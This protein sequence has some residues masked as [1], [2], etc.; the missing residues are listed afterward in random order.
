M[1]IY[2]LHRTDRIKGWDT[3]SS[4]CMQKEHLG[5]S[6]ILPYNIHRCKLCHQELIVWRGGT[7]KSVGFSYTSK[8]IRLKYTVINISYVNPMVTTKKIQKLHK[9]KQNQSLSIQEN[10]IQ[11]K[12]AGEKKDERITRQNKMAKVS[13]FL[14]II[15][16]NINRLNSPITRVANEFFFL[17]QLKSYHMLFTRKLHQIQGHSKLKVER[18]KKRYSIQMVTKRKH[19]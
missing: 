11:R 4:Q 13:P 7:G 15:T 9:R 10:E 2:V 8:V 17:K 12:T 5:N 16:L 18:W 14:P 1:K 19:K 6:N 3:S